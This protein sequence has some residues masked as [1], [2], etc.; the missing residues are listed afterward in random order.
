MTSAARVAADAAL[1]SGADVF[2]GFTFA[3]TPFENSA[4]AFV[5]FNSD[6]R[7]AFNAIA[8]FKYTYLPCLSSSHDHATY[9]HAMHI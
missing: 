3:H 9:I 1:T 4:L 6:V 7:P 5:A 8:L 2:T